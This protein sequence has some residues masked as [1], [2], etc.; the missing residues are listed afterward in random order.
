MH[1]IVSAPNTHKM[2]RAVCPSKVFNYWMVQITRILYTD[3][4]QPHTSVNMTIVWVCG[5]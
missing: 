2:K 1:F 5:V 4:T 3:A